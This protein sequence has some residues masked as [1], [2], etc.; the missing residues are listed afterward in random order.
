MYEPKM[1]PTCNLSEPK[2][3]F[4]SEEMARMVFNE[5]DDSD[6]VE[7]A[8]QFLSILLDLRSRKYEDLVNEARRLEEM[9]QS[10][11]HGSQTLVIV[12]QN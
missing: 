10:I 12:N 9:A 7:I 1:Q 6:Q 11:G 5:F 2:K 8:K 3:P 4:P